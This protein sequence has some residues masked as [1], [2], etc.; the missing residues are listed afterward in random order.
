MDG[1]LNILLIIGKSQNLRAFDLL[2]PL[3]EVHNIR[4]ATFL[5]ALR[6]TIYTSKLSLQSFLEDQ[7]LPGYM[8][9]LEDELARADLVIA[10]GFIDQ[11][12]QQALRY[13]HQH[14]KSLL[15]FSSDPMDLKWAMDH[16][17]PAL[18]DLLKFASGFLVYSEEASESLNFV[19]VENDRILC[20]APR[21]HTRRMDFQP[22]NRERFRT[23][24]KLPS[25]SYLIS[26]CD[27]LAHDSGARNLLFALKYLTDHNQDHASHM[28]LLFTGSGE[29]KEALKYLA[30]DLGLAKQLLFIAQDTSPFQKDLYSAT[31][32]AI[33]WIPKS[34]MESAHASF[35]ILEAMACG[36]RPL[37]SSHHPLAEV[38]APAFTVEQND[39][40]TLARE[41]QKVF[42]DREL[43]AYSRQA[44]V[45]QC[46]YQFD[47][48]DT[49]P[50]VE[51]FIA[52]LAA[53]TPQGTFVGLNQDFYVLLERLKRES[54]NVALEE[55]V[56]VIDEGLQTWSW[57]PEFRAQLQLF[58]GHLLLK[59]NDLDGAMNCF[60]LCTADE[61]VHREAYL[62]LARIAYLTY[63]VEEAL[64][65]YRKALAIKPNDPESMAG[66]GQVYRKTGMPDDAVYWLG[67]SLSVD[68][69]NQSTLFALTQASLECVDM[70]RAIDVLEQLISIMGEKGSVVMALGQLYYK[71]GECERGR[72]LVDQALLLTD[73]KP[74]KLLKVSNAG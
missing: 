21:I 6:K 57:H 16:D 24:I 60:E 50:H 65:F 27:P 8:L 22:K 35:W 58:K 56:P 37:V 44:L 74:Y 68:I 25:E 20:L 1:K 26:C 66:L 48:A 7:H 32:L 19:G 5:H 17:Q 53:K 23:Y 59:N 41:L 15:V 73:Q 29:N 71:V 42:E 63:A 45:E 13:C 39:Y 62:G 55:L 61:C 9:G 72:L 64:S 4:A 30:V 2:E 18:D 54:G 67:R 38:L 11:S 52:K 28:R 12:T 47:A 33:S 40:V 70:D 14:Q 43:P 10:S 49:A 46:R 34:D 69:E 36:A 31:D 51:A 3:A